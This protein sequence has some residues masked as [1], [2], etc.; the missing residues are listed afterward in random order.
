MTVERRVT[1]ALRQ[2]VEH[3]LEDHAA[4]EDHMVP[5]HLL[6]DLRADALTALVTARAASSLIGC[7][8][9]ATG[10]DTGRLAV[11][12]PS[13]VAADLVELGI[14]EQRADRS[15]QWWIHGVPSP[16][17]RL[18]ADHGFVADREL[19]QMTCDLPIATTS[20]LSTRGFRPGRDEDAWLA[21]NNRAFDEH[22]EQAGWSRETLSRRMDA[23]W[24]EPEAL[25]ILEVDGEVAAFCWTKIHTEMRPS[26]GEIYIIAVDPRMHGR[27]LGREMTCAGLDWMAARGITRAM[28]FV[29]ATNAP[30]LSLYRDL[31]FTTARHD[32]SYV[33][34]AVAARHDTRADS[35][36]G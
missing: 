23:P 28:L 26:T 16:F 12:A 11:A 33:R 22:V 18:A 34:P 6:A 1:A 14:A 3:F 4:E 13:E 36:M 19:I 35:R 20:T 31:G 7:V 25:R 15:L 27:G 29:D 10:A 17:E 30:A 5:D 21:V 24:F 8:L 2:E 9:V 32:R